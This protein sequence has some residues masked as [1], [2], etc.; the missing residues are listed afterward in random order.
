[1]MRDA[2]VSICAQTASALQRSSCGATVSSGL[3]DQL[4]NREREAAVVSPLN[5]AEAHGSCAV[6]MSGRARR[7]QFGADSV[8]RPRFWPEEQMKSGARR[9]FNGGFIRQRQQQGSESNSSHMQQGG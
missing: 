3:R 7:H 9:S 1:M 6:V 4:Q 2:K 5:T 8:M